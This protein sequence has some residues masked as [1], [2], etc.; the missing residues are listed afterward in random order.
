MHAAVCNA[1]S[2]DIDARARRWVLNGVGVSRQRSDCTQSPARVRRNGSAHDH[3]STFR[4]RH[5]HICHGVTS[6]ATLEP[7]RRTRNVLAPFP[8][9]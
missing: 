8:R 1:N 5:N 2:I 3:V 9:T 4:D 6:G 7:A